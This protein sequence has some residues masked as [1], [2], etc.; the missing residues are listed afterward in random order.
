VGFSPAVGLNEWVEDIDKQIISTQ[1]IKSKI[2]FSKMHPPYKIIQ[3]SDSLSISHSD[4]PQCYGSNSWFPS[5]TLS[6]LPKTRSKW[7]ARRPYFSSVTFG[8]VNKRFKE[9]NFVLRMWLSNLQIL[10]HL[11]RTLVS[12]LCKTL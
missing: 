10:V 9:C 11:N 1:G 7:L 5:N 6:L 4:G 12:S 8:D 3:H 2:I